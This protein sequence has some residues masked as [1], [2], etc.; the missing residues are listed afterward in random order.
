MAWYKEWFNSPYYHLLY[1]K[2]DLN[3]AEEWIVKLLE[4]LKPGPEASFLDLA[5]GKGRHALQIANQGFKVCGIDLSPESIKSASESANEHLEFHVHDMRMPFRES[6]FDYVLNLFT[7]F[8]YFDNQEDNLSVLKS[9]AIDLKPGGILV[10]DY[11]NAK[12]VKN[13]FKS[14]EIKNIEGI[15]FDIQKHIENGMI[16]KTIKFED[17]SQEYRYCEQ[18]SLFDLDDFKSMYKLA[19]FEILHTFG[20]YR[21]NPFDEISSDRLIIISK[22]L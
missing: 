11:F 10:Q 7:S 9:I 21:L 14:H 22:T 1:G 16:Y 8:G 20:D 19:G 13:E 2:R 12:K 3:E 4:F 15:E 6:E 17:A 5:C 18:V